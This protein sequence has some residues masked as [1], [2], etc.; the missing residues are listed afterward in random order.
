MLHLKNLGLILQRNLRPARRL[1]ARMR[2]TRAAGTCLYACASGDTLAGRDT[3]KEASKQSPKSCQNER[4]WSAID[5]KRAIYSSVTPRAQRNGSNFTGSLP[6]EQ[7]SQQKQSTAK[8]YSTP[9]T[10]R[11]VGR[12][13]PE[14]YQLSNKKHS[15]K[16]WPAAHKN[17]TRRTSARRTRSS[18]CASSS[19]L[20]R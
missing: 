11:E 18:A 14:A 9:R 15:K 12:I 6:A 4:L 5:R 19:R 13:S 20:K 3:S 1:P 7:P 8:K 2:R 10:Q 16:T 17:R